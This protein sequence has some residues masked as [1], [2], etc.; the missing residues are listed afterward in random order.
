MSE[1]TIR[2][3]MAVLDRLT[4]TGRE[5]AVL[6]DY[7]RRAESS[8]DEVDE[9]VYARVMSDYTS[10]IQALES[11]TEPLRAQARAE[12]DKLKAGYEHVEQTA[13]QA[14]AEK[15]ELEFRHAVGE[16]D[17]AELARRLQEPVRLIEEC[18]KAGKDL[19]T[20]KIRFIEAF[21]SEEAL[22]GI[23]TKK[24]APGDP[25]ARPAGYRRRAVAHVEG[26]DIEPMEFALGSI[27][28]IGRADD[29][30]MCIPSRG[31]SRHHAIIQATVKGFVV[32]DLG[33]QNGTA[34]NGERV[35]TQDVRDGD[36]I[37]VGQVRIEL[38]MSP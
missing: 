3:D 10:R 31:L 1:P 4:E 34:V 38:R 11:A 22:F 15:T 19:D 21:G 37:G 24:V 35:D 12:F 30:E 2:V 27:A 14:R 20:Q 16:F 23:R 18:E 33:S 28:R 13:R 17:A 6:E 36:T 32:R 26:D 7:R 8:K 5:R 29:N 9:Q 25:D